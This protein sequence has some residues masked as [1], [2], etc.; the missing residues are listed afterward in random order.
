MGGA[1][2]KCTGVPERAHK[3]VRE[4]LQG[5]R[6]KPGRHLGSRAHKQPWR[7]HGEVEGIPQEWEWGRD[8]VT[9]SLGADSGEAEGSIRVSWSTTDLYFSQ[10]KRYKEYSKTLQKMDR[11]DLVRWLKG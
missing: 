2:E 3:E 8:R 10:G 11:K 9:Y 5:G 6:N 4:C 7:S 1:G